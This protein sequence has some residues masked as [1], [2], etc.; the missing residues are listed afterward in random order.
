VAGVSAWY[1][2][3]GAKKQDERSW[4]ERLTGKS[5]SLFNYVQYELPSGYGMGH[6][7][8]NGGIGRIGSWS[9]TWGLFRGHL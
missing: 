2:D 9:G 5:E 7:Q 4:R 6:C 8:L 1:S 3:D